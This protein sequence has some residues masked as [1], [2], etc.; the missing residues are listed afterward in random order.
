MNG[1]LAVTDLEMWERWRR[2]RDADAFAEIVQRYGAMVTASS[3]RVLGD[4]GLAE[5]IAQ[6]CFLQLMHKRPRIRTSIGAWLHQAA[7]HRSLDSIR[8][9][10][11]RRAREAAYGGQH[12][13]SDA[14][15]HVTPEL[16]AHVDEAIAELPEP[17]RAVMV[18]RFMRG[19]MHTEIARELGVAESTVRHR[20]KQGIEQVRDALRKRGVIATAG[21]IS[22]AVGTHSSAMSAAL[23]AQL[24]AAAL[25]STGAASVT[26][27]TAWIATGAIAIMSIL[28]GAGY[29]ALMMQESSLSV[30]GA[31]RAHEHVEAGSTDAQPHDAVAAK[32][33]SPFAPA[34]PTP[35]H[36]E[37]VTSAKPAEPGLSIAGYVR[38]RKTGEGIAGVLVKCD[39]IRN[40]GGP[41]NEETRT[42]T[43]GSFQFGGLDPTRHWFYITEAPGYF[44][45]PED[46]KEVILAAGAAAEPLV[47]EL[48]EGIPI[49]GV[50]V[51]RDGKPFAEQEVTVKAL[52]SIRY[53]VGQTDASGKF[54]LYLP[55]PQEDV[56]LRAD[57]SRYVTPPQEPFDV[58]AEGLH[59]IRLEVTRPKDVRISGRVVDEAG[60]PLR[61]MRVMAQ[62]VAAAD[63]FYG[64]TSELVEVDKTGRFTLT[65][66][67]AG[68][69]GIMTVRKGE[70]AM[71]LPESYEAVVEIE[72]GQHRKGVR[73]VAPQDNG[74]VVSGEVRDQDGK[75]VPHVQVFS[76][77]ARGGHSV[78]VAADERGRF[79]LRDLQEAEYIVSASSATSGRV[80]TRVMPPQDNLVLTLQPVAAVY[81]KVIDAETGSPV[82]SFTH[83]FSL[84]SGMAM[85]RHHRANAT[86]ETS[87]HGTFTH[88]LTHGG[89]GTLAVWGPG[90]APVVKA[91]PR[92][93]AA[94]VEMAFELE[95]IPAISGTVISHLGD[96]VA[97]AAI[98]QAHYAEDRN[99]DAL[100]FSTE[101]GTF[102]LTTY[103]PGDEYL[104]AY[105]SGHAAGR[106]PLRDGTTITL[107]QPA[108]VAVTI[109]YRGAPPAETLVRVE[110][111]SEAY[112]APA[113]VER[114]KSERE[115]LF[116][117][118][119]PG[120]VVVSIRP[121]TKPYHLI[122]V[123]AMAVAG[124]S[125]EVDFV[126]GPGASALE[127]QV[128]K[129]D[130]TPGEARLVLM[131]NEENTTEQWHVDTDHEGRYVFEKLPHG[132]MAL[133]VLTHANRGVPYEYSVSLQQGETT[134]FDIDLSE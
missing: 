82:E 70:Y 67:A 128:L 74:L 39:G 85:N 122:R 36:T 129:A 54:A 99:A 103:P 35:S 101:D 34:A 126:V 31:A 38:D 55:Y 63:S 23:G 20:A 102:T 106:G 48:N 30:A 121:D 77:D 4:A 100:T 2:K 53:A 13:G 32:P 125:L 33:E 12:A 8:S 127:G 109:A 79:T 26:W 73:V 18:A 29:F 1:R 93:P 52:Y 24:S 50:C 64:I 114:L 65:D 16:L 17:L 87:A 94:K 117:E 130:G 15:D 110:Y 118:V 22:A 115:V 75:P 9:D 45:T 47:F 134:V 3:R 60:R 10:S 21:A 108:I 89:G 76:F 80:E 81:V 40:D 111:P 84:S 19:Q 88:E 46:K 95:R 58:P 69:F 41:R 78:A 96:P 83:G 119:T 131:R 43:D 91:I 133:G 7:V 120:P 27:G 37:A 105:K 116:E 124:E 112:E 44:H 42:R 56:L 61:N 57:S 25:S 68:R 104:Y 14:P 72:P 11:R 66:L 6:E 49:T 132:T 92:D 28:G 98:L 59:D 107:P 5:D 62:E 113:H 71:M 90:F 51:D 97:G 86:Q 123:D